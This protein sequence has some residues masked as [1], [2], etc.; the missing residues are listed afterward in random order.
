MLMRT[1]VAVVIT[2]SGC[3][4]RL[5]G[6]YGK[7]PIVPEKQPPQISDHEKGKG[8]QSHPANARG[9]LLFSFWLVSGERAREA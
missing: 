1:I 8:Q 9:F 7:Q 4:S 2:S 6:F 3:A 5:T